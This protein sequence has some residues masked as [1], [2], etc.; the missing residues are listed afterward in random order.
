MSDIENGSAEILE[1]QLRLGA[2]FGPADRDRVLD[3][4][5]SLGRH[6]AH[7]KPE[8]VDLEISVKDRSGVEQKVT[9]EAWLPGWPAL[10]ATSGGRELDHALVEVRKEM[11]RQIEDEKAKRGPHKIRSEHR[12]G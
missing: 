7:W 11:I 5:S 3:I 12:A 9:L 4:L 6:L 1:Q 10:V 8:R 2:G